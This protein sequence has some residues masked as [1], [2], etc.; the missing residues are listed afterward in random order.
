MEHKTFGLLVPPPAPKPQNAR[1]R[2]LLQLEQNA[3]SWYSATIKPGMDQYV[4]Q[5]LI[6]EYSSSAPNCDHSKKH[7]VYKMNS[8]GRKMF[9]WQCP[10][11]DEFLSEWVKVTSDKGIPEQTERDWSME[12]HIQGR[13]VEMLTNKYKQEKN[14]SWFEWYNAYL[15]SPEWDAK[16]SAVLKRAN[17]KCEGCG[18]NTATA[19]HHLTYAHVG[20]ELLF[21]L[22]ALCK[23]CHKKAHNK[24]GA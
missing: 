15:R 20:N 22:A 8:I 5:R 19:V 4:V 24:K 11:C 12:S 13:I 10:E 16:R 9:R 2:H 6:W 17:G 18:K 23:E 1:I 7:L 3:L 14:S 21:E